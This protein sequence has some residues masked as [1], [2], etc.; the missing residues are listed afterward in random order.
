MVDTFIFLCYY[1]I[2]FEER[3]ENMVNKTNSKIFK[4][5]KEIQVTCEVF[6]LGL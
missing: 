4:F 3:S 2:E 6:S 1:L 5:N